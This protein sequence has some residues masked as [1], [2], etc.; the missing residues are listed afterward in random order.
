M[1]ENTDP[2]AFCKGFVWGGLVGL[3]AA[4]YARGEF[5]RS[6]PLARDG[7]QQTPEPSHTFRQHSTELDMRREASENAGDPTRL[8]PSVATGRTTVTIE[9]SSG[10]PGP[11]SAAEILEVPGQ[12]G[13]TLDHSDAAQRVA[14]A[15]RTPKV[16]ASGS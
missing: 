1:A 16:S 3:V 4:A 10:N 15:L 6:E 13:R 5:R 14:S 2:V 8:A 7:R 9:R 12:H 11:T